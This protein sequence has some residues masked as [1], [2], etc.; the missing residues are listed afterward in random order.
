MA[1]LGTATLPSA[2]ALYL[3]MIASRGAVGVL[4]VQ[5]ARPQSLLAPEQV[6]WLETCAS[7]TALALERA[8]LAAEAQHA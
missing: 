7:Q 8:I 2:T 5:S 4:A 1:G 6:H 3:P